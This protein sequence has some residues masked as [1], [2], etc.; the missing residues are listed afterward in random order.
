M[1][2]RVRDFATAET[3]AFPLATIGG[4]IF[5]EITGALAQLEGHATSQVAGSNVAREGTEQKAIAQEELLE[6]LMMI[7]RTARSLDHTRPGVHAKFRVPPQLSATELMA[8]A[9]HFAAEATPLKTDFIAYGLPATF[10]DDLNDQIDEV[11][12]A[13]IDQAAGTRTRVTATAGISETLENAFASVRRVDPIV[14]NVFRDQPAKLA[15]WA[16]ARHLERA[17]KKKKPGGGGSGS[18]PAT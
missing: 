16:S 9:E 14:R 6:L 11:R 3:A 17:P 1:L 12:A 4:Q 18:P 13:L 8:V 10:L 2:G 15:A 7:R 5:A